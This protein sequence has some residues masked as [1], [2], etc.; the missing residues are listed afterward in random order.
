M[1]LFSV[2]IPSYNRALLLP[3]AIKSVLSQTCEDFEIILVDDASTDLTEQVAHDLKSEKIFYTKHK[4]NLGSAAARN[5]GIALARGKYLCF[6]DS[7]DYWL[8]TK[9]DQQKNLI[10]SEDAQVLGG[11][12]IKVNEEDQICIPQ[13]HPSQINTKSDALFSNLNINT[14]SLCVKRSLLNGVD[15]FDDGLKNYEDWDLI[16]SL[17]KKVDTIYVAKELSVISYIHGNNLSTESNLSVKYE[18]LK[19]LYKKH[20]VDFLQRRRHAQNLLYDLG[21]YA[22]RSG[23]KY[24]S[25]CH[26]YNSILIAPVSKRSLKA[27]VRIAE[28]ILVW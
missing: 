17:S 3:R 18:S 21:V 15:T 6:L 26:L 7:D 1:P 10:D 4:K 16:I 28:C 20:E 5:S 27:L 19:Y 14:S 22:M 24:N 13:F 8:P 25:L 2:I 23:N 9:L 12:S 11:Q